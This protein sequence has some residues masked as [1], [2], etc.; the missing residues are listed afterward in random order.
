LN[1][2]APKLP[3]GD[4]SGLRRRVLD[5]NLSLYEPLGLSDKPVV[6]AVDSTDVR[7]Y[8]KK[9]RYVKIHLAVDVETKQ[10]LAMIVTT[11]GTHDSRVF[12]ELLRRTERNGRVSRIIGNGA[13][14]K[15]KVY[16]TLGQEGMEAIVKPRRNSRLDTPSEPRREVVTL[17]ELLGDKRWSVETAHSTLKRTF[18]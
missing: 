5:L 15:S 9:K 3:S 17:Y 2:L 7:V 12:S 11:N 16:Q 18:G 13:Y 6:F 1:R 10:A 8:G 4:Y 14:D